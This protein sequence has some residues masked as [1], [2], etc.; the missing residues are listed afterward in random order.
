MDRASC[1]NMATSNSEQQPGAWGT[2]PQ[3]QV[4]L[5]WPRRSQPVSL[6]EAVSMTGDGGEEEEREAGGR[7]RAEALDVPVAGQSGAEDAPLV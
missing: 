7:G 6:R 4:A 2:A 5:T 3:L 1:K